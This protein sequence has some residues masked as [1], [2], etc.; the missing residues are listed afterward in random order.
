MAEKEFDRLEE[1]FGRKRMEL[2]DLDRALFRGYRPES[3]LQYINQLE[4]EVRRELLQIQKQYQEQLEALEG[5]QAAL[6]AENQGYGACLDRIY[7]SMAS[8]SM[9][10]RHLLE[11][12]E[13]RTERPATDNTASLESQAEEVLRQSE[14]MLDISEIPSSC[15]ITPMFRSTVI[16]PQR[17]HW[18]AHATT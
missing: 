11:Q 5:T 8:I 15:V 1:F 7:E 9:M 10:F 14:L 13:P 2:S 16:G 4:I 18:D 6:R 12:R 3:V 17:D